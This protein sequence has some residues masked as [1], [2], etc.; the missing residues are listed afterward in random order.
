MS[1]S[2]FYSWTHWGR[3][4]FTSG[5]AVAGRMDAVSWVKSLET[6][7][8]EGQ[9]R[10][11]VVRQTSIVPGY[12]QE[13]HD[14]QALSRVNT[15]YK[16]TQ[17]AIPY[18]INMLRTTPFIT[19]TFALSSTHGQDVSNIIPQ[20]RRSSKVGVQSLMKRAP[21]SGHKMEQV[22][23]LVCNV[24]VNCQSRQTSS[25]AT[26]IL[27]HTNPNNIER[28]NKNRILADISLR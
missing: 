3:A 10:P 18:V 14:L 27:Q 13:G 4:D 9:D 8:D 21:A 2:V 26:T 16:E 5:R 19:G 1:C 24:S 11:H 22:A 6:N 7:Y 20:L 17:C 23:L 15:S 12:H 25:S 28:T